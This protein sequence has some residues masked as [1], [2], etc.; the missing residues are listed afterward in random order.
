M[1]IDERVNKLLDDADYGDR[2]F[3]AN[4]ET[5][6]KNIKATFE[7]AIL[8]ERERCAKLLDALADEFEDRKP[9]TLSEERAKAVRDGAA[10]IREAP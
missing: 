8:A 9:S 3:R 6:F 10:L 2:T 4:R 1:T 7:A 5:L